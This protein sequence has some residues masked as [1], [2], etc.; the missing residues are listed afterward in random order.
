[1]IK[2]FNVKAMKKN[3]RGFFSFFFMTLVLVVFCTVVIIFFFLISFIAKLNIQNSIEREEKFMAPFMV[4]YSSSQAVF[5]EKNFFQQLSYF[6]AGEPVMPE[7][8]AILNAYASRSS[9][10]YLISLYSRGLTEK[11][12]LDEN[13]G[14]ANIPIFTFEKKKERLTI[15]AS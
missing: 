11:G 7:M 4:A 9:N 12:K 14:G 8:D 15:V 3:E 10:S 2:N 13:V 5:N 1:M 6:A